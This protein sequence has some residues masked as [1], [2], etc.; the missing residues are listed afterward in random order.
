MKAFPMTSAFPALLIYLC[1]ESTPVVCW[2]HRPLAVE[3]DGSCK[4][5]PPT[6][7][8]DTLHRHPGSRFTQG[9][10]PLLLWQAWCTPCRWRSWARMCTTTPSAMRST[11]SC[12]VTGRT[13][14]ARDGSMRALRRGSAADCCRTGTRPSCS[15]R[16]KRSNIYRDDMAKDGGLIAGCLT[17]EFLPLFGF[18]GHVQAER[19]CGGGG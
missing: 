12:A 9:F 16:F 1:A 10:L 5:N 2:T 13:T 3:G 19:P 8:P 18:V 7:L 6:L 17:C 14:H 4:S 15:G 11:T